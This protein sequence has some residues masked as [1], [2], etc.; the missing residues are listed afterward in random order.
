MDLHKGSKRSPISHVNRTTSYMNSKFNSFIRVFLYYNA[1]DT[2]DGWPEK[3]MP[4]SQD[5]SKFIHVYSGP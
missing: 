3:S 5:F 1:H 2:N 4:A